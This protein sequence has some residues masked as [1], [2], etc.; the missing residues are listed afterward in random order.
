MPQDDTQYRLDDIDRRI[1]YTLMRESRHTTA[2][3]IAETVN[4]SGATVR[5]RI[6]N[7]EEAGIISGYNAHIDFERAGGNLTNLYL[8]NVPVP[9]REALAHRAR[10]IPGVINVR[11][12]MTGR[13]NLHVV[14]VGE[15]TGDL[16]RVA[17]KLSQLGIEI[18]DE[19]LVEDE[20]FSPYAPF[21][22]DGD[23]E[24][25]A[26]EDVI[27]LTGEA[28]IVQITV[29]GSAP[30][31]GQSLEEASAEGIL[32]S[33]TLVIGIERDESE[34]TPHGE[35][36]VQPDDIV[37]VLSRSPTD[38]RTLETFRGTGTE[39]VDG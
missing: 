9:E 3:A 39:A 25:R 27:S 11:T 30:I 29:D 17:R 6:C 5:N 20:F 26:P 21:D 36:V 14:A 18:E 12:L 1:L 8:C 31:V 23:G 7:L 34:L 38:E 13:E 33:D 16:Q 15:T 2:A 10:A 22:P 32:D 24:A 35:T 4:V 37:T 28:N 19:D